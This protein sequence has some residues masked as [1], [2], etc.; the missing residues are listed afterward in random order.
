MARRR[1]FEALD[2]DYLLD[3]EESAPQFTR[4]DREVADRARAGRS[5]VSP[6]PAV[7]APK[8][9]PKAAQHAPA[10]GPNLLLQPS[11]A[12]LVPLRLAAE[13]QAERA[14]DPVG[15]P[16]PVDAGPSAVLLNPNLPPARGDGDAGAKP[17]STP[18]AL[19]LM[20]WVQSSLVERRI[21][22]NETAAVVHFVLRG[23][24][25]FRR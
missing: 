20:R 25:W 7:S 19:E 17:A 2:E 5:M 23:W 10:A 13:G 1:V 15:I 21:K 6:A 9:Q 3:P 14:A 11:A 16:S 12:F 18:L 8:S 4:T 24:R 22:Y